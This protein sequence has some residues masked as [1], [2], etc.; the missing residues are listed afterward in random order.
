MRI[1]AGTAGGRV[2]QSPPGTHARPTA[3]RV[4]EA[5]FSMISPYLPDSRV[6]DLFSGSGAMALEAISRGAG[7]AVMADCHPQSLATMRANV[8][9]LGFAGQCRI[10][11]GDFRQVLS[12]LA[13][14][15]AVFDLVFLDPP[16]AQGFYLPA[17]DQLLQGNL[18]SQRCWVVA[19]HLAQASVG[20]QG[21]AVD[22]VRRYGQT[23]VTLLKKEPNA[24]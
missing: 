19:E 1:V 8:S 6:L 11:S 16:Y 20:A 18:L 15:G 17:L 4:R 12:R 2:I 13:R 14:E 9:K 21:Y 23:A 5:I 24:I 3:D 10:E 7:Q 22:R